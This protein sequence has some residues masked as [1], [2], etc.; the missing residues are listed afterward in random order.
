M[1]KTNFKQTEI[2][3]IPE[4]WVVRAFSERIFV[5]PKRKLAK[6]VIAKKVSMQ[7]VKEHNKKVQGYSLEKYSG[8]AKFKNND[9]IMARITPCLENGKT[10]YVDILDDDEIAFGS[11]EFNVLAEKENKSDSQFIYYLAISP[12]VRTEVIQSMVGTS[13]RQRASNDIFDNLLIPFPPLLEQHSI[14]KIL[15]DLDS[16]IEN[17]QSQNQTLE[18]MGKALFKHWFVDFEFPDEHGKPYKS[19]G[20]KMKE[21]EL[22]D[23]PEG[24]E[25]GKLGDVIENFD[26]QRVPLSSREREKRKG[27]Y[28]YYGA[29]SIMDYVDDYLFDGFYL[30]M[31]EDGSVVTE[32]GY[33]YLQY[34]WDKFW[35]NNH[36]H[37]LKGKNG[38][39]TE[40]LYLLLSLTNVKH[41]V[42]GA[43]QPK[44][45]QKN[46]NHLDIILPSKQLLESFDQIVQSLFSKYR[47]NTNAIMNLKSIRDSLLPKLM[48]GKIRV[49]VEVS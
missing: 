1:Q 43:V 21:T 6:G 44:I 40:M 39:S 27:P 34:V 19:N 4:E 42:T 7:S 48:S 26:S 8:G 38:F 47:T 36:A 12:G 45:N 28:P 18:A 16:Q 20:G 24:W 3:E 5:N 46:M 25:V 49:P 9:T 10:A 37:V 15:S 31:G 32:K 22:G 30:L 14:A 29:T 2:G 33:P 41:I 17:L 13:G 35:V 23:V 11:T